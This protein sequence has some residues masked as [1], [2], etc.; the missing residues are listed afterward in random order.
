MPSYI[1]VMES[2]DGFC[3]V[4]KSDNPELR[5]KTIESDMGISIKRLEKFRCNGNALATERKV[6]K[7]LKSQSMFGEWFYVDFNFACEISKAEASVSHKERKKAG[8]V[9]Q[10]IH[11]KTAKR[12][13]SLK[14]SINEA[15]LAEG[16]KAL[17]VPDILEEITAMFEIQRIKEINK[18]KKK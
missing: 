14:E 4:G 3:K 9:I 8:G 7:E 6:H 12:L 16:E 11:P 10:R 18:A 1:Y 13:A 17:T 2:G 5:L 15:R